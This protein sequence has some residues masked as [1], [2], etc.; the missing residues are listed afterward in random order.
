ILSQ[1]LK[2]EIPASDRTQH[3]G[4][5]SVTITMT[6]SR[7]QYADWLRV[8]ELTSHITSG[9]KASELAAYLAKKEIARRTKIRG[10]TLPKLKSASASEVPTSS[11][12]SKSEAPTPIRT[13]E[14]A[15]T[16]PR[17]KNES[18]NPRQILPRNR[19]ILL[20]DA[21]CR[22]RDPR[23]GKICGSRRYVQIDH[24]QPVSD[25][26]TRAPENLRALCGPHNRYVFSSPT[27]DS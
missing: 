7:E 12:T 1:D 6:L 13:S 20:K 25:G 24:I 3:H 5:D 18:Q 19:K 16:A 2:F 27:K 21:G 22:F 15:V 10:E 26:G 8:A 9:G 4:D 17:R 11:V 23:T 14:T